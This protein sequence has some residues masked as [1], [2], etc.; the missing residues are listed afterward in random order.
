MKFFSAIAI[1]ALAGVAA[2][3]Q[4]TLPPAPTPQPAP[5]FTP[6]SQ[7]VYLSLNKT[8]AVG[9]LTTETLNIT[10]ECGVEGAELL[11]P[12]ES[13]TAY[14]GGV[15]CTPDLSA[16][17]AKTLIPANAFAF[18]GAVD[19]GW[20]LNSA[21]TKNGI[22]QARGSITY[23][24][25]SSGVI[26]PIS[27]GWVHAPGFGASSNGFLFSVGIGKVFGVSQ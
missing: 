1:L 20:S 10:H 5:I 12:G 25:G 2:L 22:F 14:M 13:M 23:N 21:S 15:A 3:A 4:G 19:G 27:F 26:A 7:A 9:N 24:I 16:I 6:A 8:S 17:L 11:V 18:S